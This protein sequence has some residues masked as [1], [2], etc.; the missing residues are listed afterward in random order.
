MSVAALAPVLLHINPI[1]GSLIGIVATLIF[2]AVAIAVIIRLRARGGRDDKEFGGG[3]LGASTSERNTDVELLDKDG[4]EEKNPDIVPNKSYINSADVSFQSNSGLC[5][6]RDFRG[7]RR[8]FTRIFSRSLMLF[9]S[10][11]KGFLWQ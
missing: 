3:N 9:T 8:W 6:R 1:L 5:Y 2:V 4:F 11:S 10:G 7:T